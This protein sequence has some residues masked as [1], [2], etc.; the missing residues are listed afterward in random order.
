LVLETGSRYQF[1]AVTFEGTTLYPEELLRRYIPFV[2]GETFSYATLGRAQ[3]NFASSGYFKNVS[4]ITNKEQAVNFKVPVTVM[5]TP[6]PR[7]VLRPGAGYG[8]DTGFR[9]SLNYRDLNVLFPGNILNVET[10]VSQRFQ[11]IGAAYSIPSDNNIRSVSTIQA[12]VQREQVN[13]TESKLAML[14]VSRSVGLGDRSLGTAYIRYLHEIYTTGLQD[15]TSNLLLPGL[16]FLQNR[17]D[18]L[19]NPTAGYHYSL[20]VRGTHQALGSDAGFI[21]LLA[22]GGVV[23]PLPWQLSLQTRSRLG[24]SILNDPLASLP[25]SLRFFAG[26][27]NSVRGYGYKSLAPKDASGAVIGGK[28]LLQG[29]IELERALFEQWGVSIFFDAG[30][31]FDSFSNLKLYEGAG[32]AAHYHTKIGS[33]SLGLARQ[34]NV[35]DPGYRVHFTIGFQM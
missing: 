35:P 30:N 28:Y 16:R 6:A 15:S 10:T 7:R 26:G 5:L 27:D 3:L 21:Q 34:I 31:A 19:I 17:Y 1:G 33:V 23:T 2:A 4:V 24:Y 13:N 20:E 12:N 18:D 9:G 25:A 22:D 32:V 11:G 29:S 8:T 14:D